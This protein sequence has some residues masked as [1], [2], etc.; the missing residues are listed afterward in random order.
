MKK[1]GALWRGKTKDN[2]TYF[3]GQVE[4]IAGLKTQVVLFPFERK[5]GKPTDKDPAYNIYLSEPMKEGYKP[6]KEEPVKD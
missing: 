3:S 6:I 4:V 2:K 5:E 1:L